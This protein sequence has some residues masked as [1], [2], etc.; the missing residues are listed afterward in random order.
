MN[1]YMYIQVRPFAR[2]MSIFTTRPTAVIPKFC[3]VD[4]YL[5]IPT[6]LN[7][8]PD[9][10]S[11]PNQISCVTQRIGTQ[12][13]VPD[14]DTMKD[15]INFYKKFIIVFYPQITD[16]HIRSW[17]ACMQDKDYPGGRKF[18][19]MTLRK[20]MKCFTKKTR[21]VKGFVKDEGYAKAKPPR[22][23][24]SY[25]D[26]SK[27]FF[28]PIMEAVDH[29]LFSLPWFVKGTNP[30]NW[31]SM[32]RDLFGNGPVLETDFSS[33]EA[34]HWGSLARAWH[35]AVMHI[36]RNCTGLKP[37]RRLFSQMVL[38]TNHI[39]FSTIKVQLDQGLMSGALWT[40]SQNASLNLLLMVYLSAKNTHPEWSVDQII[41]NFQDYFVCKAE[42]DDAI[43]SASAVKAE[44]IKK[45]GLKLT[46]DVAPN[47]GLASFCGNV[48]DPVELKVLFDPIRVLRSFFIFPMKYSD[49]S[50]KVHK[51]LSRCKAMSYMTYLHDCPI[52]GVLCDVVCARTRSHDVRPYLAELEPHK[53]D[54]VRLALETKPWLT[55]S[56]P[57]D[58]SRIIVETK[59][60]VSVARQL[61]IEKEIMDSIASERMPVFLRDFMGREHV[62]GRGWVIND[63]MRKDEWTNTTFISDT[64]CNQQ[65]PVTL[66]KDVAKIIRNG[67]SSPILVGRK[68][69]HKRT[70]RECKVQAAYARGPQEMLPY[71]SCHGFKANRKRSD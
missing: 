58:R 21:G 22:P 5:Q 31:A 48:C 8:H 46:F 7:L 45:L 18:V 44:V 27:A 62:P 15:F 1:E 32:L 38:G 9:K 23:I 28:A 42:G 34:H 50:D 13:D 41:L 6:L 29:A 70:R 39:E 33:M 65:R 16:R 57:S 25:S 11:L 54:H 2:R 68:L 63:K 52:V 12:M 61:Q 43:T 37:F 10:R 36:T 26:E 19:L 71:E 47:F 66:P 14:G 51:T 64:D 49:S 53:R 30:M 24:D 17:S 3:I 20:N 4:P 69:K 67:E 59:F 55:K 60:G 56:R 40:S 35:F